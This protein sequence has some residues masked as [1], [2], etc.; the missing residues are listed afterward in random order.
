MKTITQKLTILILT[1]FC[2]NTMFGQTLTVEHTTVGNLAEEINNALT[3]NGMSAVTDIEHLI[4]TGTYFNIVND[5]TTTDD[6]KAIKACTNVTT[7]D[8]SG[9]TFQ[10]N[11]MPGY[12]G[13]GLFMGMTG[14]KTIILPN[15]VTNIGAGAFRQCSNLE[16][17]LVKNDD[18]STSNL[19]SKNNNQITLINALAFL[20]CSKLV[21][22]E[23]PS[24]LNNLGKQAFQGCSLMNITEMPGFT[25]ST[26]QESI[27]RETGISNFSFP[28]SVTTIGKTIFY[29]ADTPS[30][31]TFTF[32][33]APPA[34]AGGVVYGTIFGANTIIKVL[35]KFETE[36][37]PWAAAGTVEYLTQKIT[38]EITGNGTVS[39]AGDGLVS[40]SGEIVN[41]ELIEAYEAENITF[42]VTPETG[43]ILK[44]ILL[45]GVEITSELE[46]TIDNKAAKRLSV[47]FE[48]DQ[49]T[50][51]NNNEDASKISIYPNPTTDFVNIDGELIAPIL[52][53]DCT[54]K[55]IM[56]TRQNRIDISFLESGIYILNVN[57]KPYKVIKR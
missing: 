50:S 37:I 8:I 57:N 27:F 22:T 17:V 48:I 24:S 40:A 34:L 54:G 21:I 46:L 16:S 49:I 5:N 12:D 42:T 18:E 3:E 32:R 55:K 19:F 47:V 52:L 7:I 43:Y 36:Y 2:A 51:I 45:D 28:T 9:I 56:E 29:K 25:N 33:T 20:S 10:N 41:G 1:F 14:L 26:F 53:F 31:R 23:V 15:T 38:A 44:S 11:T 30:E 13:R 35:K 6:A 4:I 39:V